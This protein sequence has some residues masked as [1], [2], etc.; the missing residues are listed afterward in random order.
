MY[1]RTYQSRWVSFV[2]C[3]SV[4]PKIFHHCPVGMTISQQLCVCDNYCQFKQGLITV[5]DYWFVAFKS[6]SF[7]IFCLF[8]YRFIPIVYWHCQ[9]SI[10]CLPFE[11]IIKTR[12]TL[13]RAVMCLLLW[14]HFRLFFRGDLWFVVLFTSLTSKVREIICLLLWTLFMSIVPWCSINRNRCSCYTMR[15]N[16]CMLGYLSS[17]VWNIWL[18]ALELKILRF[19]CG[20]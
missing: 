20:M 7:I 3:L 4:F 14:T 1:A 9:D 11:S 13:T 18:N 12:V 8:L 17:F 10:C 2:V 16:Q 15:N 19:L 6:F 5:I